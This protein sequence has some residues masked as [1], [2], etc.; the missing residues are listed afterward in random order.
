MTST[1]PL[2][3]SRQFIDSKP[4]NIAEAT[5]QDT[6]TRLYHSDNHYLD[7]L[8]AVKNRTKPICDVE[9]GHRTA[10]VCNVA[11][12]AYDLHRP[13]KWNPDKEKFIGDSE[14]NKLRKR[15]IRGKWK[16]K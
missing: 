16:L 2:D 1:T 15:P 5:I 14:A 9:T 4:G 12:I 6:E 11:N 7:F 8:Q 10:T 3:I 13:L